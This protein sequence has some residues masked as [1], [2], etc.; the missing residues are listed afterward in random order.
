MPPD[1]V[2]LFDWLDTP[3]PG[4]DEVTPDALPDGVASLLGL[5][6]QKVEM[7]R[8]QAGF[9]P[10][11]DMRLTPGTVLNRH[12]IRQA[13]LRL[14]ES[15]KYRDIQ[16]YGQRTADDKAVLQLEVTPLYRIGR[17][18]I[19]GNAALDEA[20]IRR[21]IGY[22]PGL[23]VNPDTQQLI[24][25]RERLLSTYQLRGYHQTTAVLRLETTESPGTL[26][27][28][29]TIAEGAP[30][31]Y[32]RVQLLG[33]PPELDAD[34]LRHQAS[35]RR[36]ILRDAERVEEGLKQLREALSDAGYLDAQIVETPLEKP[37]GPN[38]FEL[39]VRLDTGLRTAVQYA[40]LRR[41][42]P[43]EL[44]EELK[45]RDVL[46]TTPDALHAAALVLRQY[47]RKNGLLHATVRAERLCHVSEQ[48]SL[49]VSAAQ[50]CPAKSNGQTIVFHVA[51]GAPVT[52]DA[53]RI[54]GNL[55]LTEVQIA[56]EVYAWMAERNS[57]RSTLNRFSSQSL[58]D[59]SLRSR[60]AQS[61]L[62]PRGT[63]I[64]NDIGDRT[65]VPELY[66]EVTRYIGG[67]YQE[68]G[69]LK[70]AVSHDC[71]LDSRPAL[72]HN[73]RTYRP[74]RLDDVGFSGGDREAPC[75]FIS[76]D[77]QSLIAVFRVEENTQTLLSD[78]HWH[79]HE[80][81]VFSADDL[82]RIGGLNNGEPYNE[83]NLRQAVE[84]VRRAYAEKGYLF[85]DIAWN[86]E[87]SEDER[88]A[89]ATIEIR[90]G[91]QVILQDIII[92]SEQTRQRLIANNLGLKVG[93]PITP[94]AL[95]NAERRLMDMGLFS[96]ATVKMQSA[97][98][99]SAEKIVEVT[100]VDRKP[101]Y[102]ELRGGFAT[103]EGVRAG[104][105]YGHRNIMGL[106]LG[107]RLILRGN[108]RVWFLGP[109]G[110]EFERDLEQRFD[111]YNRTAKDPIPRTFSKLEWRFL[112]GLNSRIIPGTRGFLGV[113]AD[114]LFRNLNRRGYSALTMSPAL[115]FH[116]NFPRVFPVEL[117]TAVEGSIVIPSTLERSTA[118]NVLDQFFRMPSGRA[119][120]WVSPLT[121]SLDLRDN[122][123]NPKSGFMARLNA[124][125][126]Q[127]IGDDQNRTIETVDEAGEAVRT[128]IVRRSQY[129]KPQLTLSGY[130]PL[131][132]T[133]NVLALSGSA[134]YI[135]HLQRNSVAW[136]DRYFYMGGGS[137][138]RG[139]A[140][141]SVVAQDIY[142]S[143]GKDP[144]FDQTAGYG[145]ESMLVLRTEIRHDFGGNII[146]VLFGEAGNIWRDGSNFLQNKRGA[147]APWMLRPV[148]GA[149]VHYDTPVGPIAFD[150]GFNLNKR[151]FEPLAAWYFSIG[152]AF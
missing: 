4:E 116:T 63:R 28:I 74:F 90:Q 35:L 21:A 114:V 125:Y 16:L 101:Q 55:F 68:K 11:A 112:T 66:Q 121:L 76:A 59:I 5:R 99:V 150:V 100:V 88:H 123:L 97:Q 115:R 138:L 87:V 147:F 9:D 70:S 98:T 6:L 39:L 45:R 65:Y 141:D 107:F 136:A 134:G 152:A 26:A 83:Y 34:A 139:F 32:T 38:R 41:L 1:L 25:W 140:A 130:V 57:R 2:E 91:P 12:V 145:G 56:T 85:T 48:R 95:S 108:Y 33:L 143:V 78:I 135:F 86:A 46:R 44:T 69:F 105:Q 92:H 73:H 149:G 61:A 131:G 27:L 14:W 94:S 96:S 120:F 36:H 109:E 151:S 111:R 129:I 15:G 89:A 24:R 117:R 127:T 22:T 142:D 124:D 79:G 31:V 132:S 122:S 43:N 42:S 133:R 3:L 148:A 29:V 67:L 72:Q 113:G 93:A 146:G 23:P 37:V 58:D 126:V 75:L 20:V 71:H 64:T 144:A 13:V 119:Y 118:S 50:S 84:N 102:L 137:S 52:V 104:F 51:E 18:A 8:P 49:R 60:S 80:D 10:V 47:A 54:E 110:A 53:I 106:G 30:D 81:G 40:G 7:R 62:P 19:S 82:Q 128:R 17:V 77:G 103:E